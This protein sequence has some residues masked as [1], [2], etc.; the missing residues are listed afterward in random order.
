MVRTRLKALLS[1]VPN[2]RIAG[3]ASGAPEAIKGIVAAQP[4][5]ALVDINLAQGTG[6]EVLREVRQRA[7]QVEV[8]MLS[9]FATAPYRRLAAELGASDFFDKSTEFERVRDRVA[10]RAAALQAAA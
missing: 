6:F 10:H 1:R 7:P 4:Q 9:N 2:V 5:V 8:Y 3:M